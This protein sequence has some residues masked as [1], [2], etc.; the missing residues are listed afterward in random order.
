MHAY[1]AAAEAKLPSHD[2]SNHD[3]ALAARRQSLAARPV[4]GQLFAPATE[5]SLSAQLEPPQLLVSTNA[6]TSGP[7]CPHQHLQTRG[8]LWQQ[9]QQQQQQPGQQVRQA[10][11]L[12][13]FFEQRSAFSTH[14]ASLR[15]DTNAVQHQNA[16]QQPAYVPTS[17]QT[18]RPMPQEHHQPR[19]LAHASHSFPQ[20]SRLHGSHAETNTE[21]RQTN[22][23][24]P[25]MQSQTQHQ[26]S[27][28][29]MFQD[30][31]SRAH[32]F[33][34]QM[35]LLPPLAPRHSRHVCLLTS[36]PD[37]CL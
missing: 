10:P 30:I 33:A 17:M 36:M 16:Q 32:R 31:Q 1:C 37:F 27:S 14:Q 11:I 35:H 7:P 29:S 25:G 4:L 24:M 34:K 12:P 15:S 26:H 13:R 28:S 22:R 8:E 20:H 3:D 23:S 6:A 2:S 9:Q 19:Q 18:K 5:V 21:Q